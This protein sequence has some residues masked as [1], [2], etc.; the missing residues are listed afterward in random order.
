MTCS[1]LPP[2]SNSKSVY[3]LLCSI[4]GSSSS[5]NF[6]NCSS[7]RKSASVYATYLRSHFSVSQP[8]ALCNRA[9]GYVSDFCRATCSEESHS[10]FC[11]PYSP[12]KFHAAASNLSFSTATGPDKVAY[13]ML[14]SLSRSGM[15]FL[16]IFILSWSSHFFLPSGIHLLLFPSTRWENLSTLLLLFGL[17][18]SPPVSQR[19]LNASFYLIYSSFW[20]QIP[21]SLR[22]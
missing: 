14:K 16:H 7:C 21:F 8:K 18:L 10:S 17:S 11:F 2:K 19:F 3:S 1:S 4:A 20:N 22:N 13:P 5:P 6:S 12:A 15:D 9:R